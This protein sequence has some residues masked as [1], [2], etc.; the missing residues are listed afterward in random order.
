[1]PLE[2]EEIKRYNIGIQNKKNH[3]SSTL[4]AFEARMSDKDSCSKSDNKAKQVGKIPISLKIAEKKVLEAIAEES[5]PHED[6]EMRGTV[7]SPRD[8]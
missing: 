1:M 4:S 2:I 7:A 8:F 5:L 3:G 6:D